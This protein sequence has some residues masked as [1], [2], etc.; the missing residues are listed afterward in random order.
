M[1]SI[2]SSYICN[3][4]KEPEVMYIDFVGMELVLLCVQCGMLLCAKKWSSDVKYKKCLLFQATACWHSNF[5]ESAL[6]PT[7]LGNRAQ[8]V[9]ATYGYF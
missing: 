1:V 6:L 5:V 2:S 4:I 9:Q 7:L 8:A 3:N